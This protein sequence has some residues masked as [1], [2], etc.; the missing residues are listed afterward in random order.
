MLCLDSENSPRPILVLQYTV[1]VIQYVRHLSVFL[2]PVFAILTG[3]FD[4]IKMS[5]AKGTLLLR[6]CIFD[7]RSVSEGNWFLLM[8][9]AT[10][11]LALRV[12]PILC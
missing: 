1:K 3:C 9:R 8:L 2:Q 5:A 4:A 12:G 11:L 6:P 10:F 7:N